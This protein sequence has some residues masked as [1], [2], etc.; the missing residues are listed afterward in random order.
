MNNLKIRQKFYILGFIAFISLSFIGWLSFKINEDSF[1]NSNSVVIN[2]QDTQKIQTMYVEDLFML[3]EM[4]LSLVISPNDNYKNNIDKKISPMI[5]N[6]NEKFSKSSKLNKKYWNSYKKAALKTREYALK[7]FDE[8][9]YMNTSTAERENFYYLINELKQLQKNKLKNSEKKL[10]ELKINVY[11]NNLYIIISV[12]VIGII[13]LIIDITVI[14][15]LVKGIESVHEGLSKFFSYLNNPNDYNETLHIDIKSNDELG[16][17][18]EA[19]NKKVRLI[20]ENLDDDYRLI[21]EA[22]STLDNLKEGKFGNS[23]KK[24]GKSKELRA[25]RDVMNQMIDSLENK[26]QEEISQRINQEKLMLQQSKLAAM[27][28][29]IGNIAHQWRQ[30]I[31]EINALLMEL[32]TITR[33]S[34]LSKEHLLENIKSCNNITEHMSLTISDFQNFFKPTKKKEDFSVLQA[35][36]KALSIISASLNNNSIKLVFDVQKDNIINGYSSEFSHAFLNIISNSKDVLV[37]R[38]IEN[39]EIKISIKIGKQ[40][41]VIKILDNAGGIKSKDIDRI[42]EPYYTTKHAK[43]GTGIGLYMTKMIIENNMQGFVYA[44]NIH[45]GALFTIKVN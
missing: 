7:G 42:F 36:K 44:K 13:G 37:S 34:S 45:N 26:I 10:L 14:M 4:I 12:I 32:E 24:E 29:M 20:R 28:E 5:D 15:K 27:G 30:P 31:S 2:F 38:K 11:K 3:R 33:Y 25:L 22:I 21:H 16:L 17:M 18:S 35:C 41:T 6:L 43:Q 9:A 1:N 39:P 23:I 19:I 8:G 40:F